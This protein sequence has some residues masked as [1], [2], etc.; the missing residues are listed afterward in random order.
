MT[1]CN[2]SLTLLALGRAGDALAE[3]SRGP[4]EG[5]RSWAHAIIH[6]GLGHVAESHAA[7]QKLI[8]EYSEDM[9][10]QIAQVFAV[11]GEVDRA[12][13]WLERAYAQRDSGLTSMKCTR[14]LRSLHSDP[15]WGA[16]LNKMGLEG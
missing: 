12:F 6:H 11:H 13:E 8:G 9:A 14:R 1:R 2:L 5:A 7:L 3:G 16:F 4:D 15:R 10:Y